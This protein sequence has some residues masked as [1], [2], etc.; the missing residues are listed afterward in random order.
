MSSSYIDMHKNLCLQ[1]VLHGTQLQTTAVEETADRVDREE[2]G[3]T[4]TGKSL[5]V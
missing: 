3:N 5:G 4:E 1:F 2:E